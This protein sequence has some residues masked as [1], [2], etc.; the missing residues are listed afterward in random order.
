MIPAI[1][2]CAR[3]H[4]YVKGI[5]LIIIIGSLCC[6]ETL[7]PVEAESVVV[8]GGNCAVIAVPEPEQFRTGLRRV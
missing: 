4:G 2:K 3:N 8:T 1:T 7:N 5:I 6:A